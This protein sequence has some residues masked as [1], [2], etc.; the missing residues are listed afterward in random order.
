MIRKRFPIASRFNLAE[1]AV[2]EPVPPSATAKSVIPV[3]EPP[4]I[5]A[6]EVVIAPEVQV[7]EKVPV[8]NE[9]PLNVPPVTVLPVKV[10]AAGRDNVGLPE[11][12]SPLVTVISVAVPVR[13]RTA[14]VS[15]PMR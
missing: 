9:P 6:E 8:A 12:P 10:K 14:Q 3:T 1:A 2:E 13:V 15:A 4:V 7:P 11:T 5:V